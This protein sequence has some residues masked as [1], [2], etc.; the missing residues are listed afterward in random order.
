MA[1]L[2]A[3]SVILTYS[4]VNAL[5]RIADLADCMRQESTCFHKTQRWILQNVVAG[6]P[7]V[8]YLPQESASACDASALLSPALAAN[9]SDSAFA[10]RVRVSHLHRSTCQ[11][12]STQHTIFA[13]F[14]GTSVVVH[15]LHLAFLLLFAVAG[16]GSQ[17]GPQICIHVTCICVT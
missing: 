8:V 1:A 15:G 3:T 11:A 7:G 4:F 14:A 13:P 16:G 12:C 6:L 10:T 5:Y 2:V 17:R 9:A